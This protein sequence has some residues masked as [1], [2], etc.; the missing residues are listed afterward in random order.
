[1]SAPQSGQATAAIA[2]RSRFLLAIS[3]AALTGSP[4]CGLDDELRDVFRGV[5]AARHQSDVP[6]VCI[7]AAD[8]FRGMEKAAATVCYLS[9]FFFLLRHFRFLSGRPLGGIGIA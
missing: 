6:R 2:L 8:D 7:D 1:M 3:P 4:A 9:V 5:D